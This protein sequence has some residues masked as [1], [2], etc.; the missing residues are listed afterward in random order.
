MSKKQKTKTAKNTNNVESKTHDMVDL[1]LSLSESIEIVR[2]ASSSDPRVKQK[3]N[4]RTR[5]MIV[6]FSKEGEK[7]SFMAID[8]LKDDGKEMLGVGFKSQS[9]EKNKAQWR[10]NAIPIEGLNVV[11]TCLAFVRDAFMAEGTLKEQTWNWP[12]LDR[13]N[14]CVSFWVGVN[15]CYD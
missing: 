13:P 2:E 6:Y 5:L 10:V 12:A 3:K 9:T 11:T 7:S 14:G 4:L 1:S 8:Y 15:S